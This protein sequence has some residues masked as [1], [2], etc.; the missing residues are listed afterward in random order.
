MMI[1]T[2]AISKD[3]PSLLSDEQVTRFARLALDGI[4]REFPNKPSNVMADAQGVRAPREMH[5][6]FF[7]SF[8]W[9]SSVHGHWM[10]IRLLK[11]YPEATVAAEIR[12]TLDRQLNAAGL[13]AEA[14]YFEPKHNRSFERMY[15]WAW[16]LRLAA[17]LHEFAGDADATRWARNFAPLEE[18]LLALATDYLPK[19]DWPIRCGFHPES[20]FALSQ[21]LDY[22]R[23]KQNPG[24]EKL[25]CD[26]ARAFYA[27]DRDYPAAYE[28][29]GNDFFS[30]GL[31]EADLMRRVLGRQE[32]AA[33]LDGFF[34]GLRDGRCGNLLAPVSVSD[35]DDGHLIHLAGLNLSRAWTMHGILGALS[36]DDQ[37]AQP[38]TEAMDAHRDAGLAYVFSGSY[39]GEHWLASFAIYLLTNAGSPR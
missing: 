18:K 13:Q 22:A 30:A 37:R 35:V 9:H 27:G 19:L 14:D 39:E 12:T 25:V 2:N 10:L 34:P 1:L 33:W 26:R 28:P 32:F 20:A 21:M 4:V 31:N 36:P 24:F 17:E 11:L 5:P 6:V 29:S 23:A 7:G 8:D 38:L 15:G 16:A 3:D